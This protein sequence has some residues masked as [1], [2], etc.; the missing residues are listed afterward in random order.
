MEDGRHDGERD[1]R[2]R[3]H[4][5][6]SA[7]DEPERGGEWGDAEPYYTRREDPGDR[8]HGGG[9]A[10]RWERRGGY[11]LGGYPHRMH[12]HGPGWVP[13]ERV[14]SEERLRWPEDAHAPWEEPGWWRDAGVRPERARPGIGERMR[15]FFRGERG[16]YAGV[17][18]K[19][20]RRSDARIREDVCDRIERSGWVDASDV[21]V[22]VHDGEVTL[23]GT[24]ESR[25][26]KR[27]VEDIV[28]SVSGVRDVHNRLRIVERRRER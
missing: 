2:R 27:L 20:Y 9:R 11:P 12:W 25:R 10:S 22:Q 23:T 18:P 5:S 4:R 19:G 3:V 6:R 13:D 7:N 24:I 21:E 15:S 17:G 1:G 16:P 8:R 14:P 26:A 28:D